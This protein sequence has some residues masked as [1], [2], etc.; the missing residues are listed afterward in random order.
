MKKLFK[1]DSG[2]EHNFWMSYTDLMS[3]FLVVFIILSAILFNHFSRK[4]GEA[5]ESKIMY[6]S[7]IVKY[8]TA[9]E[10]LKNS[11]RDIDSCSVANAELKLKTDSLT[12]VIDSLRKNDMKN[13]VLQY[14]EFAGIK[15]D[16]RVVVDKS[17]GSIVL[18]HKNNEELFSSGGSVPQKALKEFLNLYG[19]SI[20][21]KTISLK[22]RYPSIELRIEG[23][24]DPNGIKDKR[25]GYVPRYGSEDSFIGNMKL[26]SER[27]NSVYSY[28]YNHK[29]VSLTEIEKEFLRN[30]AISVGYSFSERIKNGTHLD[31]TTYGHLDDVSRRI[32]FRIIA[33]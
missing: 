6:D 16:I 19:K 30:H 29:N 8:N 23:H 28:L 18:Y 15:G 9:I 5:E 3:G 2:E 10:D 14:S 1:K 31:K 12:H 26:S 4:S 22:Q 33:K 11:G 17:K 21:A 20:I 24:A 13:L 32:E 27:A 7:L 25:T